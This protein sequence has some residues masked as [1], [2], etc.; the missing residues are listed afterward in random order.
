[1][2]HCCGSRRCICSWK[3]AKG[4]RFWRS[5]KAVVQWES[6]RSSGSLSRF[7]EAWSTCTPTTLYTT[8][9]NVRIFFFLKYHCSFLPNTLWINCFEW[10]TYFKS[11]VKRSSVLR[12]C[13]HEQQNKHCYFPHKC[14]KRCFVS[15]S[16]N[17][18]VVKKGIQLTDRT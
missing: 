7:C 4:A 3:R 13:Y 10:K 9:S 2:G 11:G 5:W 12:H 18:Y 14:N 15:K 8:T 6:S 1:M 16:D 17:D